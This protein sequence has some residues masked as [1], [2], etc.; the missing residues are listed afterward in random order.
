M[1]LI[2]NLVLLAVAVALV[3]ALAR[4]IKEPIAFGAERVKREDAVVNRLKD[5]RSAQ[6]LYRDVTGAGFARSF[7]ELIRVL[8]NDNIPIVSI[9]GD[10]DDPDFD[11]EIRYDTTFVPAIDSVRQLGIELDSLPFVPYSGGKRFEL[12][13]DTTT[14]QSTLVDVVQVKTKYR[15]FMGA[16]A[17]ARFKRYDQS[18]DPDKDLKFGNLSTPSLS[19][20]WD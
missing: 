15:E 10:M 11:G 5:I 3:W 7:D 12:K 17:D 8:K 14:Y 1:K 6:Q 16:Y 20:S 13:A 19:G 18:Y 2:I 4:S 9:Y